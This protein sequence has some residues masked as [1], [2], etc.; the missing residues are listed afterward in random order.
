MRISRLNV[1]AAIRDLAGD[2]GRRLKRRWLLLST[3]A[4]AGFG[5]AAVVA[6]SRSQGVG[7]YLYPSLT[8]LALCPLLVR[9]APGRW[10]YTG[11]SLAVL[12]WGWPRTRC[13]P[14]CSTTA[15]PPPSW[16][17]ARC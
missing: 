8:V 15:P 2:G 5:A 17:S 1:I 10:V 3:L 14:R 4:A 6:V 13:A 7:T 9:A 16:C 12:A 11:A